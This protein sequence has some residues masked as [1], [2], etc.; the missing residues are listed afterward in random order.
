MLSLSN[1]S[2]DSTVVVLP[3]TSRLPLT[4]TVPAGQAGLPVLVPL[5]VSRI[6]FPPASTFTV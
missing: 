3:S 5:A 1:V 6:M 4:I 2:L